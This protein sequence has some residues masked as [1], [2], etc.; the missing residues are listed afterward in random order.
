MTTTLFRREVFEH[1]Q[2][3]WLGSIHLARPLSFT[4]VTLTAVVLSLLLVAFLYFGE[5]TRKV[6]VA[7]TLQPAAGALKLVAPAAGVLSES[8]VKEGDAVE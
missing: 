4:L 7:G 3:K 6:R 5:Y 1:Q 8:R 2:A